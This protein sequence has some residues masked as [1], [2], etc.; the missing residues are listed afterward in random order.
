MSKQEKKKRREIAIQR[1][2][3]YFE[4]LLQ[5]QLTKDLILDVGL[6][7]AQIRGRGFGTLIPISKI[8]EIYEHINKETKFDLY[9]SSEDNKPTIYLI[10]KK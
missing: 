1:R 10:E 8:M 7:S 4:D 5:G 9:L 2:K 6:N 3:N